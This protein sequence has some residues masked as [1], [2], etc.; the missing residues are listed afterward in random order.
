MASLLPGA[1]EIFG[2]VYGAYRLARLDPKGMAYFD[3]SPAGMVHSFFAYVL[4]LPV[5]AWERVTSTNI[6]DLP[7]S[8]AT[9][10]VIQVL[11]YIILCLIFPVF[12]YWVAQ[13]I[14]A[15]ER[16][17]ALLVSYNWAVAIQAAAL[18]IPIG[19]GAS[20]GVP[21]AVTSGVGS[22]I[23]ILLLVYVWYVIRTAFQISGFGAAGLLF[24]DVM[25][26]QILVTVIDAFLGIQPI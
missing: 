8:V 12:A 2:G 19:L 14:D 15:E 4:A 3:L 26:T 18:L 11:G 17:P 10:V 21:E 13:L 6:T 7:E 9:I 1:R 25:L 24:A 5:L 22:A 20:A 16:Y 23:S